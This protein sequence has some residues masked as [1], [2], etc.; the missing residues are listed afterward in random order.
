V[1]HLA[2]QAAIS[3]THLQDQ[4]L[5][6]NRLDLPLFINSEPEQN[7]YLGIVPSAVIRAKALPKQKIRS[8]I[9]YLYASMMNRIPN[10]ERVIF[11]LDLKRDEDDIGRFVLNE[12]GIRS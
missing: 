3:I 10:C 8:Y 12:S 11:L 2:E 6:C 9:E 7:F 4:C 1:I 5:T